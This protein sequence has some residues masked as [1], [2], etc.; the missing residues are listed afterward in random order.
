MVLDL[1]KSPMTVSAVVKNDEDDAF[2][3]QYKYLGTVTDYK[4]TYELQV[5]AV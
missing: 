4:L 2:M 5:D 3:H 1:K